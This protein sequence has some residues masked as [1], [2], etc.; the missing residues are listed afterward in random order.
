MLTNS[1]PSVSRLSRKCGSLDVS[2][3]YGSPRPVI[4]IALHLFFII[5]V[6]RIART[7]ANRKPSSLRMTGFLHFPQT[8]KSRNVS[9]HRKDFRKDIMLPSADWMCLGS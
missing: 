3:T 8:Q 6:Q 1:P 9:T 4:G 5:Q 7:K 2:Q